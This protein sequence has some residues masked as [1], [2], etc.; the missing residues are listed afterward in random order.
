M[1]ADCKAAHALAQRLDDAGAFMAEHD[2]L[3]RMAA[4]MLVKIGVTNTDRDD[5]H[6]HLAGA[7]GF[8][9][10]GFEAGL[11]EAGATDGGGY[12]HD[13]AL[14]F[15]GGVGVVSAAAHIIAS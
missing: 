15:R 5:A 2:G 7:R 12:L 10:E 13:L 6:Q 11:G 9:L 8:Q 4:G 14:L 3:G 1:I